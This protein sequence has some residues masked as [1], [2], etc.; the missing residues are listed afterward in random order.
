[1]LSRRLFLVGGLCTIITACN[2]KAQIPEA[3]A[4]SMASGKAEPSR[5]RLYSAAKRGYIM[6]DR[7]IKTDV[8]WRRLLTPEQYHVTRE[9][10]TES[11]FTG[12][13]LE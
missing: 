12:A 3:A 4:T 13:T 9:A 8:E 5:I 1:M 2:K 6:R 11:P 7:V 10:G